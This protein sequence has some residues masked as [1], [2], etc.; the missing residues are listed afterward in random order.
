MNP[1]RAAVSSARHC[2]PLRAF[3]NLGPAGEPAQKN[4]P[5]LDAHGHKMSRW[6]PRIRIKPSLYVPDV[7]R[8][9][10]VH[11]PHGLVLG[12]EWAAGEHKAFA[13]QSVHKRGVS[14]PLVLP[15]HRSRPIP[16]RTALSNDDEKRHAASLVR[17]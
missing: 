9:D 2:V 11:D 14:V 6:R 8:L 1:R 4:A 16:A 7:W 15:A 3:L 5:G 13:F 17:G 10:Y 12:A